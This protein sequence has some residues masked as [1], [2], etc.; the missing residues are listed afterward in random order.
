MFPSMSLSDVRPTVATTTLPLRSTKTELIQRADVALY[1]AKRQ[2]RGRFAMF[3]ASM[4]QQAVSHFELVQELRRALQ[5]GELSMHYQPIINLAS[6]KVVGFEAL[7]RWKHPERGWVP[8]NSFIPLA[9]QSDL[10]VELGHF[11]I[12]ESIE[13]ASDWPVGHLDGVLPYVTINLSA[14]QFLDPALIGK[15][16]SALASSGLAAERLVIEITESAMLANVAETISVMERIA[17]LGIGFALDDFGTGYSSL[18][19]LALLHPTIIKIDRSFVS[20][21]KE[22]VRNDALLEAIISLGHK[23]GMTMLAE[24][25]ETESQLER[26][27]NLGCEFGQGFYWSPAVANDKVGAMLKRHRRKRHALV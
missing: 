14:H 23:L 20:P 16:E 22:S 3:T 27:H 11:A 6:T 8:P 9:E 15:I 4:H 1:E 26:L 18:S 17:A 19:Y 21:T 7:M 13:A 24:G 12:R 2:N 25:I 5:N 10:I